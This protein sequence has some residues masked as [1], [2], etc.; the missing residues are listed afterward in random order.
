MI[1][2]A[3]IM[4]TTTMILDDDIAIYYWIVSATRMILDD[5]ARRECQDFSTA[6]GE[7][8]CASDRMLEL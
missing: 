2:D 4:K 6:A 7:V 1:L 5:D 3:A 8:A